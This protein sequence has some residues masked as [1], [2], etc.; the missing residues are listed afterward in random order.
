MDKSEFE[1]KTECLEYSVPFVYPEAEPAHDSPCTE[2]I[3]ELA[4]LVLKSENPKRE[5]AALL[6][7]SRFD[8]GAILG[9]ENNTSKAL[10]K[11]FGMSQSGMSKYLRGV[12][13]RHGFD[14]QQA[15][16]NPKRRWAKKPNAGAK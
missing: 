2:A 9:A 15:T 5:M 6:K 1:V 11:Y 10:A 14:W 4:L 7:L 13:K 8:V 16:G 12:A 3:K